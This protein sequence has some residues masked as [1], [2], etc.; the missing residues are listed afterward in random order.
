[1]NYE[2]CLSKCKSEKD[3]VHI[4]VWIVYF[5]CCRDIME[6][7]SIMPRLKVIKFQYYFIVV[8]KERRK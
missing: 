4:L 1:M 8:V 6:L 3:N 7:E 5:P 2:I